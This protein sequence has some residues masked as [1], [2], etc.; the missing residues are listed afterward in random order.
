MF[1]SFIEE[2]AQ[3]DYFIRQPL[4]AFAIRTGKDLES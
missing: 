4:L 2:F 1:V 3:G